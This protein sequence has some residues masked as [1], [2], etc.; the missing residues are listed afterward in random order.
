MDE[1]TWEYTEVT[2]PTTAVGYERL[3]KQLNEAGSVGWEV[4]GVLSA[5]KTVGFNSNTAILKRRTMPFPA[6]PAPAPA[7]NAD[8]TGR[9]ERRF[10]D[11]L[12]W[13]QHVTSGG[14]TSIDFPDRR[15]S[16]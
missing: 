10:W 6:P 2:E 8:P 12:R 14:A 16:N 3:I 5:D 15:P 7:W 13:T 9:F 1:A 4:V 11:G